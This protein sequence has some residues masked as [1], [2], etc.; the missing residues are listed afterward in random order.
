[1]GSLFSVKGE[2]VNQ[3]SQILKS[4]A[5]VLQIF[6][7]LVSEDFGHK[8]ISQQ[9]SYWAWYKKGEKGR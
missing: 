4:P 6:N 7:I 3:I 9:W 8:L 1:M 5:F 2:A